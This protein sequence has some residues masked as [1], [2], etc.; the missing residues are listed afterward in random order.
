MPL[1][2]VVI[3]REPTVTVVARPHFIEPSHLPVQWV[4][5][6]TDGERVAEF[7]GRLRHMSQSN[8]AGRASHEYLENV[9]AQG[10]AT[11][12]DHAHYGLLFEGV[13][14]ALAHELLRHSPALATAQLSH[15]YLDDGASRFVLP[16]AMSGDGALE[17]AWTA[18]I[19][20]AIE[21][22]VALV[23]ALMTRYAWV[24]DKVY[25]RRMA[26]DAAR[27][28]LPLSTETRILVTGSARAWRTMVARS[29]GEDEELEIR[30]L[31]V[32]VLRVMQTEVPVLFGDAE[33]YM[34]A[35]RREAARMGSR[36]C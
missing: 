35:D 22:Y 29:V 36:S 5:A 12:F 32:A 20:A 19:E 23:S 14:Q 11:V 4:G 1:A 17:Q 26:R 2:T 30:R 16:P 9:I 34:A 33:I 25:R 13:S 31:A 6:A 7:A 21:S 8:P 28:V 3:V 15:R 18:Q 27:G 24:D 10:Q